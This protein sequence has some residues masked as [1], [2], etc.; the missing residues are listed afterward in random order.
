[1]KGIFFG[2]AILWTAAACA[3]NSADPLFPLIR[4][5]NLPALEDRL[6]K[7]AAIETRDAHGNTPLM[8][9]AAY[10]SAEG[11]E[12]LLKRGANPN[13]K[14]DFDATALL[15]A[16][17]D[18]AKARL[19]IA[20]GADVNARSKNGRTP[21]LVAATCD[22]CSETV[23]LLLAKGADV[24]AA[25]NQGETALLLATWANDIDAIRLLL[26]K[27]AHADGADA[28]GST[29][30]INSATNCNLNAVRL[31]LAKGARVNAANTFAGE[32]KFGKIQIIHVNSLMFA[33]P[34]CPAPLIGAL[35][36]AGANVNDK[37][38]RNMTA[39]MFA[40]AS[41]TQDIAVAKR[42]IAAGADVNVKSNMGET[43]LDWASKFG[44]R[45]TI[46]LLK[47]AGARNGDPFTP[48]ARKAGGARTPSQSV[49]GAL[50]ILQR[51]SAE[52]FRQSGC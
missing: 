43:A 41:E 44:N 45:E 22:G 6:S 9:A 49:A 4:N 30:L 36:D 25:D 1:M 31:L 32:V 42:L 3:Q 23:R 27:G 19:L 38:S 21:L 12:L 20:K 5:N 51:S 16:A 28:G 11:V 35:L 52:F 18:P 17:N 39:L 29:P 34:Y 26:A 24:N 46:A 37:D 40:V 7:G 15:W 48:P 10:G 13:A 2:A 50:A 8:Y 47:S 14:N 33:A